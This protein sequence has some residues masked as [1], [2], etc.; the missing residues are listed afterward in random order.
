M[1]IGEV[2]LSPVLFNIASEE[3]LEHAQALGIKLINRPAQGPQLSG[4]GRNTLFKCR[5]FLQRL[6]VMLLPLVCR[7]ALA[8]RLLDGIESGEPPAE[9]LIK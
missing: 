5:Q 2:S 4:K 8:G 9:Y 1:V 3:A 6:A 7:L